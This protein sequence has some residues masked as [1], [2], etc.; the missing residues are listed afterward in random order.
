MIVLY[1]D[2]E[3]WKFKLIVV[4]SSGLGEDG[5]GVRMYIGNFK[6]EDELEVLFCICFLL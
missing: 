6:F 1:F 4:V 5:K 2:N 3:K